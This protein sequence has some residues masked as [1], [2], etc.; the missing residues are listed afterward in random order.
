[1]ILTHDQVKKLIKSVDPLDPYELA[2]AIEQAVLDKL[3]GGEVPVAWTGYQ[4]GTRHLTASACI[5]QGMPDLYTDALVPVSA[6][7]SEKAKVRKLVGLL[8]DV[9][10]LLDKVWKHDCDV[11]GILHNDA[12]DTDIAI[13][14]AIARYGENQNG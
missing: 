1:M 3:A 2:R 4:N 5:A 11:F 7:A 14:K 12:T 6:L 8:K 9:K 10:P 13:R